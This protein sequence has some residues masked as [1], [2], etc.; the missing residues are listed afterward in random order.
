MI[1]PLSFIPAPPECWF[2]DCRPTR[3][4]RTYAPVRREPVRSNDARHR[5]HG[6]GAQPRVAGPRL[7][8]APRPAA[9]R[10]SSA[11]SSRR[12]CGRTSPAG[13]YESV[14]TTR[15][16]LSLGDH[17]LATDLREL[18]QP[19]PDD[20][21]L[22]R[23]RPGGQARARPRRAA[24]APAARDPGAGRRSAAWPAR[25]AIYLAD[26]RGRRRRHGWGVAISTDTALALGVAH[27]RRPE[28]RD[29]PARL[30]A[31]ARGRSTTSWRCVVIAVAYTEAIDVVRA[32]R[33][34]SRSSASLIALRFAGALARTR[35]RS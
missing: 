26:Q 28:R 10:C 20:A 31:H 13:S 24:R 32:R 29:A 7:P 14:W 9:R 17:A 1:R 6:V 15:L 33:S 5:A 22:P 21:L 27:P 8:R 30:P 34:R 18:G 3:L 12:C 11:P 25:S 4:A 35:P 19:G 23:R 16:S 2:S